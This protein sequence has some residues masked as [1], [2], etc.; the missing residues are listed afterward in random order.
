MCAEARTALD[1]DMLSQFLQLPVAEQQRMLAAVHV[2]VVQPRAAL[3]TV[4]HA[5]LEMPLHQM[6]RTLEI[7]LSA[8]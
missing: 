8:C 2:L 1:G 3:A 7:A 5:S 6:I 4:Q